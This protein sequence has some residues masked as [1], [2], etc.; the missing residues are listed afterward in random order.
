ML[1]EDYMFDTYL[2]GASHTLF[3]VRN[4]T[5]TIHLSFISNFF[6][7]TPTYPKRNN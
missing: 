6:M 3:L 1:K 4:F 7:P 2:S 5:E